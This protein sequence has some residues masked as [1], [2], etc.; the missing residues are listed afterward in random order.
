[1]T[2]RLKL[3]NNADILASLPAFLGYTPTS[4]V[5]AILLTSDNSEWIVRCVLRGDLG[6]DTDA[7]TE[8]PTKAR[9]AFRDVD[10][11]ILIGICS[12]MLD[13]QARAAL[14][15]LRDGLSRINVDV[16][17]RLMARDT[18]KPGQWVD[19]DTGA[20]GPVYPYTDA[21]ATAHAVGR[22]RIIA[23]SREQLV[24]EFDSTTNPVPVIAADPEDI[25]MDTLEEI[26]AAIANN[27]PASPS[28]ATRAGI[29]ITHTVRL[30]DAMLLLG[31][32]HPAPAA[33]L[34]T[35]IANQLS[36]DARVQALTIAAANYYMSSDA[37]RAGIALEIADNE[38]AAA[39]I[40]YPNLAVLLATALQAGMPPSDIRGVMHGILGYT[41][42]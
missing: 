17:A 19:I 21:L 23:R 35:A 4:S 22:G 31:A 28:L 25:V 24:A 33:S 36:G 7:V 10:T 40:V 26:A 41:D 30:R 1:M 9:H 5:V 11:A 12:E 14:D 18:A 32:Q 42:R 38:A 15:A 20:T 13:H 29:L 3:T 34:W 39:E 8:F 27:T 2:D 6:A 37:V 16:L